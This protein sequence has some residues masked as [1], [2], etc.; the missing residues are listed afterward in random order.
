MFQQKHVESGKETLEK[1]ERLAAIGAWASLE[2][3]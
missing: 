3:T 1:F 2:N